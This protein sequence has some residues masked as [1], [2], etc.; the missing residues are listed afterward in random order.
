MMTTGLVAEKSEPCCGL[1]LPSASRMFIIRAGGE[2]EPSWGPAFRMGWRP[3]SSSSIW[4][5]RAFTSLAEE[6]NCHLLPG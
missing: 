5:R 2:G 4:G 1:P 3:T 6:A